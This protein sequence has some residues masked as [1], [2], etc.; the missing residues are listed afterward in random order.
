MLCTVLQNIKKYL[1]LKFSEA[2]Y[3]DWEVSLDTIDKDVT[4]K[5]ELLIT[6]LRVEEETSV[7]RQLPP[8]QREGRYSN[9]DIYL[10]LYV[11]ISSHLT[12]YETALKQISEVICFLNSIHN[13]TH[14]DEGA[15]GN[16]KLFEAVDKLS[17]ELQTL[18]AEESNGLWQTLGGRVVPAA[19]YKIRM[20]CIPAITD[21]AREVHLVGENGEGKALFFINDMSSVKSSLRIR[22]ERG[23]TLNEEE[24]AML[25]S[26]L[27]E[28]KKQKGFLTQK[29][30]E[31]LEDSDI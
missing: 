29:E 13:I 6:L 12:D 1:Q 23:V 28:I 21:G 14:N 26:E 20:I 2:G 24:R 17:I 27:N 7:K 31:L 15:E 4:Q 25:L 3:R 16:R 5:S 8:I 9:P 10:N 30:K 22:L 18:T 19:V 11:L